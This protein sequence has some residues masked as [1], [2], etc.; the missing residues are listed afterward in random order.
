MMTNYEG[1][2]LGLANG[3]IVIVSKDIKEVMNTLNEK[4]ADEQISIFSVPKRDT[5]FV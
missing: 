4:Y 5:V 3:K 1:K 2:C